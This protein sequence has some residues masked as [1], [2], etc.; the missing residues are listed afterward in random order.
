M[1]TLFARDTVDDYETYAEA[2][3]AFLPMLKKAGVVASTVYQSTENPNDVTVAHQFKT[4]G[5]AKAFIDSTAL[6]SARPG[7]GVHT[8]PT[9][10]FTTAVISEQF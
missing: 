5:E 4:L 9:T 10:W 3:H 7:A 1:I 6:K 2:F 8:P